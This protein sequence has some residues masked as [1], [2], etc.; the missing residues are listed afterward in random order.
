[1]ELV[2]VECICSSQL[3]E[4]AFLNQWPEIRKLEHVVFSFA[5][6][7]QARLAYEATVYRAQGPNTES[8]IA[9]ASMSEWRDGQNA[10][11]SE[12]SDGQNAEMVR[13]MLLVCL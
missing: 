5:H 9:Y 3:P 12:F 6:P 4:Y 10:E 13:I 7:L 11:T 8:S 2:D 1:M